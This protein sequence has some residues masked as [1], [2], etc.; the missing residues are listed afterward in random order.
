VADHD[1][2]F[3]KLRALARLYADQRPGGDT[4][5]VPNSSVSVDVATLDDL[6]NLA[7][8]EFYD[9][10]V[11]ADGEQAASKD[12]SVTLVAGTA[13]YNLNVDVYRILSVVIE[14]DSTNHEPVEEVSETERVVFTNGSTWAQWGPKAYQRR[15]PT[16]TGAAGLVATI[17]FFP[18]PSAAGTVRVRY[19]PTFLRLTE[20]LYMPAVSGWEK[21]IA[22]R[23]AVELRD[24][25]D[26]PSIAQRQSL[27]DEITRIQ[28]MADKRSHNQVPQVVDVE[29]IGARR[30]WLADRRWVP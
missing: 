6:I 9:L 5:F 18:T 28:A 23:V 1:V 30:D 12:Q 22:L 21:L 4:A 17:T 25:D 13:G 27:A 16:P 8:A 26:Q 15:A 7:C 24:L 10:L 2:I 11:D 19:V 20:G 14:W 29:R 3:E